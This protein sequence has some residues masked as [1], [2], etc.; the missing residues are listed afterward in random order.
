MKRHSKAHAFLT[1]VGILGMLAGGAVALWLYPLLDAPQHKGDSTLTIGGRVLFY[2]S[3]GVFVIC[4]A[5]TGYVLVRR[6]WPRQKV[7]VAHL[8][9]SR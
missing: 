4:T 7:V 2:S 8:E 5:A 1:I 3:V 6:F 9:A